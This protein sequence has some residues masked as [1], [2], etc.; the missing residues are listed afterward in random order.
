MVLKTATIKKKQNN[1]IQ[2][3][4]HR[5]LIITLLILINA[6]L[7]A[8]NHDSTTL[9]RYI[10][11]ALKNNPDVKSAYYDWQSEIQQI[12]VAKRLPNPSLS[13]GYFLQNVETAVGPQEYKLGFTQMIPWFGKLK[14]QGD[15]QALQAEIAHYHLQQRSNELRSN[16]IRA[17]YDYYL[18]KRSIAITEQN[19]DLVRQW[20]TLVRSKYASAR[21]SYADV[22]NVQ[23]ELRKLEDDLQ[24]LLEQEAVIIENFRALLNDP[25][26]NQIDV[27]DSLS[28][29]KKSFTPEEILSMIRQNNPGLL[30]A[31]IMVTLSETGV[32]RKKLN[33]L[34]DLGIGADYIFTGDRYVNNVK[35]T[36]S[37]KDPLAVGIS[38]SL[39]IWVGKQKA[40]LQSARDKQQSSLETQQNLNNQLS[41]K[42]SDLL[43][44]LDDADRKIRLNK[45]DLIPK[46]IELLK[47]TETAYVSGNVDF[48]SLIDAQRKYL[49]FLLDYER[50]GAR[51]FQ[52]LVQL[53]LLTG[54]TL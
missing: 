44:Q 21:K 15:L 18:L 34:P 46:S 51:Y 2:I 19:V 33:F 32:K 49:Q 13:F 16:V 30:S 22:V 27:P 10:E 45:D 53:E 31:E 41:A 12:A 50:A 3:D 6:S 9:S 35:V 25:N 42:T 47:V 36:E 39:P 38:L 48:L 7:I 54:R 28:I 26:V 43:Y 20:E 29:V 17:Y 40:D 1:I 8:N 14:L 5:R 52:I 11:T 24:T 37:G 4:F 23:I